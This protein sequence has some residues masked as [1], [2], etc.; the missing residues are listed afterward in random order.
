MSSQVFPLIFTET[1]VGNAGPEQS[2]FV[3]GAS[4]AQPWTWDSEP[5]VLAVAATPSASLIKPIKRKTSSMLSACSD[6]SNFDADA[7]DSSDASTTSLRGAQAPIILP[8]EQA[9]WVRADDYARLREFYRAKFVQMSQALCKPVVKEWIK[10][11][12]GKK[13]ATHP[14]NGGKLARELDEKSNA[15]DKMTKDERGKCTC[16]PWWPPLFLCPHKE[17]DHIYRHRKSNSSLPPSP[18]AQKVLSGA[19]DPRRYLRLTMFIERIEL[20]L[21]ILINLHEYDPAA[22]GDVGSA[23]SVATL[24]AST[25]KAE[26]ILRSVKDAERVRP[27]LAEVYEAREF[28][29]KFLRGD[30]VGSTTIALVFP[31]EGSK[32]KGRKQGPKSRRGNS[33][34]KGGGQLSPGG[35]KSEPISTDSS[36]GEEDEASFRGRS[37]EK[38]VSPVTMQERGASQATVKRRERTPSPAPTEVDEGVPWNKNKRRPKR[39]ANTHHS[40]AMYTQP[41]PLAMDDS[42][43]ASRLCT[44]HL[45]NSSVN[46]SFGSQATLSTAADIPTPGPEPNPWPNNFGV[47]AMP[48]GCY[49]SGPTSGFPQKLLS[50]KCFYTPASRRLQHHRSAP[51]LGSPSYTSSN[52]Y[53]NGPAME[54]AYTPAPWGLVQSDLGGPSPSMGLL[55]QGPG[56]SMGLP[57]APDM[58]S[59][60]PYLTPCSMIA[61]PD[62]EAAVVAADSGFYGYGQPPQAPHGLP[63]AESYLMPEH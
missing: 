27:H 62:P 3:H 59:L 57:P 46:T 16:P 49:T 26:S 36:D 32:S 33:E 23:T 1:G 6:D 11:V 53:R 52:P 51:P 47:P 28:Q 34:V 37:L 20:M 43:G 42:A 63:Q 19:A 55:P 58:G 2:F 60:G 10:T 35:L 18:L 44:S 38:P 50:S 4:K 8:L 45:A 5:S 14:Y 9:E 61:E 7:R 22:N 56:A 31:E 29:E 48:D 40:I 41:L 17:P 54:C 15:K 24:R 39:T 21:H 30:H 13:Q 12:Q 25:D